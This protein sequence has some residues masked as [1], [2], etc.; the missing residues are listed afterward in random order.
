MVTPKHLL[1]QTLRAA[2]SPLLRLPR[3]SR[4][5]DFLTATLSF[6]CATTPEARDAAALEF[7][8]F[9]ARRQLR[10]IAPRGLEAAKGKAA[11]LLEM[12]KVRKGL[13]ETPH[14]GSLATLSAVKPSRLDYVSLM[15]EQLLQAKEQRIVRGLSAKRKDWNGTTLELL[16]TWAIVVNW[17]HLFGTF[18]TERG[19][20]YA[21]EREPG[22][23][24]SIFGTRLHPTLRNPVVGVVAQRNLHHFFYALAGLRASVALEGATR[25]DSCQALA[26]FLQMREQKSEEYEVFKRIRQLAYHQLHGIMHLGRTCD[27]ATNPVGV[28][29]LFEASELRT[30]QHHTPPLVELLKNFDTYQ[31]QELFVSPRAASLVLNHAR[32]FKRWWTTQ[33]GTAEDK[34]DMLFS[35]PPEWP[36]E[37]HVDLTHWLSIRFN[38]ISDRWLDEVRCWAEIGD[39]AEGNFLVSPPQVGDLFTCDLY[40]NAGKSQPSPRNWLGVA[41][42][43]SRKCVAAQ[44]VGVWGEQFG[45][46]VA[47]FAVNCLKLIVDS[48]LLVELHRIEQLNGAGWAAVFPGTVAATELERI[49]ERLDDDKRKAELRTVVFDIRARA[50]DDQPILAIIGAVRLIDKDN[51]NESHEIDGAWARFDG[52]SVVWRFLEEKTSRQTGREKQLSRL[53]ERLTRRS[54]KPERIN[55]YPTAAVFT[56]A[57]SEEHRA[58]R[59]S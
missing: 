40:H 50:N 52:S 12:P 7:L 29:E 59:T 45:A 11:A 55:G 51:G 38:G 31:G 42:I 56:C 58:D 46:S 20:L 28:S 22:G 9:I 10:G 26:L 21:L 15:L 39:W 36:A 18:S 24:R 23:V 17:G 25:D 5:R 47:Q 4:N 1:G 14:L 35:K 3:F 43:L 41:R 44:E 6:A 34:V 49:I 8:N 30:M 57:W 53:A 13:E 32:A 54:E 27:L 33:S 37:E 16:Q 19:L 48:T 2:V